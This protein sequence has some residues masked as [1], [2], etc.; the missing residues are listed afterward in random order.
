MNILVNGDRREVADGA[1]LAALVRELDLAGRFA[2]EVNEE[3][4]PRTVHDGHVL[5][6]GDRVE[7]VQAIGGG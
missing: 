1:T 6:P 4:V 7:I 5:H 3:L 2:V